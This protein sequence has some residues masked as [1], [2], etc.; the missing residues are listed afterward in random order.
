[1]DTKQYIKRKHQEIL[2]SDPKRR[3]KAQRRAKQL[4]KQKR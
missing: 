2:Y 3:K 1:M 4:K